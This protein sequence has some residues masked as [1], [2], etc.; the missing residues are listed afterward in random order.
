[1]NLQLSADLLYRFMVVDA[2]SC[3]ETTTSDYEEI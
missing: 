3:K 1:M 2:Q